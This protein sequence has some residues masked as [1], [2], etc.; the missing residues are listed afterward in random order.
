M[1][2]WATVNGGANWAVGSPDGVTPTSIA[3][4]SAYTT[5]TTAGTTAASYNGFE[6]DVTSSA[7]RLSGNI[8]PNSLRF[9]TVGPFTVTLATGVNSITSGGILI[10]P[11]ETAIST[12]TGGTLTGSASGALIINQFGAGNLIINSVIADHGG[13]TALTKSG[14]GAGVTIIGGSGGALNGSV[15]NLFT[16]GIYLN[17]GTLQV[18]SSSAVGGN[19]PTGALNS[20][21]LTLNGG[22]LALLVDPAAATN[23]I[24]AIA[25]GDAV[26]V[27]GNATITAKWSGGGQPGS[28]PPCSLTPQTRASSLAR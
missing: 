4:F 24:G 5:T 6:I 18:N 2:G 27:N 22:T 14:T 8:T 26:T 19:G 7:G 21:A 3:P 11:T 12:I 25:F 17:A 15:T 1:G 23:N 28:A 10:T 20:N 9:D 13:P 16:G